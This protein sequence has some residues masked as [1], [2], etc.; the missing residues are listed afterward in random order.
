VPSARLVAGIAVASLIVIVGAVQVDWS[1]TARAFGRIAWA[2]LVGGMV[3]LVAAMGVFAQRWQ[4]LMAPPRQPSLAVTFGYLAIG[5]MTNALLPL[6][7]GDLVRAFLLGRRHPIGVSAALSTIL[8]E[9]LFDVAGILAMGA[10]AA[11]LIELPPHLLVG[12]RSFAF[13]G[14]AVGM[15]V[16]AL[17]LAPACQ[18]RLDRALHG[19]VARHWLS[20]RWLQWFERFVGQ[21]TVVQRAATVGWIVAFTLFG[22]ILVACASAAF[23]AAAGVAAPPFAA[24]VLIVVATA[25]GAAIPSLPASVGVYHALAVL[26]LSVWSVPV[27]DAVATALVA[28]AATTAVH[29]LTGGLSAWFIGIP[30]L[31][32]RRD[33][34]EDLAC[35]PAP[36]PL[37]STDG[38]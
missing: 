19:L 8:L 30:V 36:R 37:L 16:F 11:F 5:Y 26:A 29:L 24:G 27:P 4:Y 38:R 10:A 1:A 22:W 25:L 18:R 9:R 20:A 12:L 2:D 35:E 28:H 13:S 14:L 6:R 21:L 7:S 33:L 32:R 23:V 17:A 15:V 34:G 31:L 3:L